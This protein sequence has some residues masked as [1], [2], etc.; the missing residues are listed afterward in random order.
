M[1][2]SMTPLAVG[3]PVVGKYCTPVKASRLHF[4]LYPSPMIAWVEA[5]QC[6][7]I[8]DTGQA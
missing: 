1:T 8:A 2:W 3:E 7:R 4:S 5:Y 6:H